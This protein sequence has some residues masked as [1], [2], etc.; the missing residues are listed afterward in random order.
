MAVA[1]A[2]ERAAQPGEQ[3]ATLQQHGLINPASAPEIQHRL[4]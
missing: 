1:A 2:R 3:I 4:G